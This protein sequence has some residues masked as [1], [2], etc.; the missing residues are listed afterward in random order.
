L[1]S[2]DRPREATRAPESE[3]RCDCAAGQGPGQQAAALA[4]HRSMVDSMDAG[5]I[6]VDE[7]EQVVFANAAARFMLGPDFLLTELAAW[8]SLYGLCKRDGKTALTP[9]EN[10]LIRAL[11]GQE[12]EEELI[13]MR[14]APNGNSAPVWLLA[15]ARPVPFS[16]GGGAFLLLRDVSLWKRTEEALELRNDA[17]AASSEGITITDPNM[18]DNPL[19]YVNDGFERLTGYKREDVLGQNCRFMQGPL[20]GSEAAEVIREAVQNQRPCTVELLNYRK[21]GSTFWNRLS[22]APVRDKEGKVR[23]YVGV[24]SD[25]TDRV[26]AER[27]LEQTTHELREANTS[28]MRNV[29]A[30]ARIQ[31]ALLPDAR[32][33]I[34]GVD[35]AWRFEPSEALAGDLLNVFEIDDEHVVFYVL[36]VSGHGTAAALLSVAVT[37]MLLPSISVSSLVWK[38]GV[39]GAGREPASPG[40]VAVELNRT[41]PW[42]QTTGQFFTIAYVVFNRKTGVMRYVTAG[43]PGL[44]YVPRSGSP[45]LLA[46][47]GLPIGISDGLYDDRMVRLAPG[48]TVFLYSDGVTEAVNPQK[49]L[50]GET[51]L[52]ELVTRP[53]S[54]IEETLDAVMAHLSAWRGDGTPPHDDVSLLGFRTP[55]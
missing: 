27:R 50:F 2:Q 14:R 1:E 52:L 34:P 32:L 3:S 21:D 49:E 29:E 15:T 41:F 18:P 40:D 8:P 19:V 26:N 10:P 7:M 36:D 48:D 24:Q 47:G 6:A 33:H 55:A 39:R 13:L 25:V 46:T 16:A 17:V 44:I 42:D 28:L 30:A 11:R 5:I 38:Q 31:K 53:A 37:R 22:I 20:T 12:V 43:H 35:V 54:M 23:N 4:L 45:A 51:R 9:D